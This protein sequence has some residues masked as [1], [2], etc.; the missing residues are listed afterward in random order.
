MQLWTQEERSGQSGHERVGDENKI[1]A[2]DSRML[3]VM[4]EGQEV[5][6]VLPW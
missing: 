1:K 4:R 6:T 3:D 5:R 2:Q